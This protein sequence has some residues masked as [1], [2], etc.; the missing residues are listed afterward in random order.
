MKQ[1]QAPH[2]V[3]H[4]QVVLGVVAI[5]MFCIGLGCRNASEQVATAPERGGPVARSECCSPT[6]Q[7]SVELSAVQAVPQEH[8]GYSLA[9]SEN[10][11]AVGAKDSSRTG[12]FQSGAVIVFDRSGDSDW[13][14]SDVLTP[15]DAEAGDH[16]GFSVALSGTFLAVGAPFG[17]TS[18]V[19]T[20]VVHVFSRASNGRWVEVESLRSPYGGAFELFGYSIAMEGDRMVVGALQA[21]PE[22]H[23]AAFVYARGTSGWQLEAILQ[24][25]DGAPFAKLGSSVAIS[26]NKILV[27]A[28]SDGQLAPASGA[29]YVFQRDDF[30]WSQ[31]AKLVAEDGA[32]SDFFGFSTALAQDTAVIGTYLKKNMAGSA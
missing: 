4:R 32:R 27:G 3:P 2:F 30:G 14:Q 15:R 25:S 12:L 21:G 18:G 8:L 26:G 9:A 24:A 22:Q 1:I 28:M 23:G 11:I 29:A 13:R 31:K 20:G 19:N 17:T 6:G 5:G 7:Q 10:T 16:F